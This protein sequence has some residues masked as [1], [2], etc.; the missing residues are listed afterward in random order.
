MLQPCGQICEACK[1]RSS[2]VYAVKMDKLVA[3]CCGV[4]HSTFRLV[5]KR[6]PCCGTDQ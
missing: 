6:F 3:G 5:S 2:G 4:I 1:Q